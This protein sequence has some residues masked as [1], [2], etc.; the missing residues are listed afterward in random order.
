VNNAIYGM[1]GGQMAPTTLLGQKTLT[2]P[3]GRDPLNEGYPLHMSELL[4]TLQAPVYIERVA[5]GDNKLI[6]RADKAI[7]RAIENQVKG[8]DFSLV[9]VLSPCPTIWK[10]EPL[11]AQ[12]WVRDEMTQ[13]FPP[14]VFCYRTKDARPHASPAVAP[15]L[16]RIPEILGIAESTSAAPTAEPAKPALQSRDRPSLCENSSTE[17]RASASGPT[18]RPTGTGASVPRRSRNPLLSTQAYSPRGQSEPV[19]RCSTV[20]SSLY[21]TVFTQTRQRA[22][23][24]LFHQ[25]LEIDPALDLQAKI[26]GFGGQGVLLLGEVLAE[27]GLE[28][29]LE[30]SW[31]PSYGPDMR[32]GTS[33]CQVR[34]S[35]KSI[36]SPLVSRPNVLIDERAI[37][38]QVL[39]GGEARRMAHLQRRGVSLGLHAP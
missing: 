23:L 4:A 15:P 35:H 10:K 29:G 2:S 31:L 39:A 34:L 24:A 7:H 19:P 32:C 18:T 20:D 6:A 13:T 30:V 25:R 17:P 14:G 36:D 26:A 38:A 12:R 8:L 11:E 33:N 27:A 16:E 1:T 3:L 9:E 28:A 5:L 21:L 22:V 37:A